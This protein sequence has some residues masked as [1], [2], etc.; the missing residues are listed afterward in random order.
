VGL[1]GGVTGMSTH[2]CTIHYTLTA[3]L[4]HRRI[5]VVNVMPRIDDKTKGGEGL[6]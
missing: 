4:N 2:L 3:R 6:Q 5:E 1:F